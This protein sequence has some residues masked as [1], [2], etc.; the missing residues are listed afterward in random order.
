MYCSHSILIFSLYEFV[1]LCQ[2]RPFAA[3]LLDNTH[4]A[5]FPG[6]RVT[7]GQSALERSLAEIVVHTAA[8]LQCVY[9]GTLVEPL[10]LLMEQP[11]GMN[12]RKQ[13]DQLYEDTICSVLTHS[14]ILTRSAVQLF[15]HLFVHRPSHNQPF[16]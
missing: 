5:G 11:A 6:L 1:L 2:V 7:P 15:V 16:Y 10:R 13:P 14:L 12:V 4:G 3:E 9:Q 8:V